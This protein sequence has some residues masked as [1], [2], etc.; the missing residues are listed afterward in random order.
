MKQALQIGSLFCLVIALT[1]LGFAMFFSKAGQREDELEKLR[2]NI[3]HRQQE[4]CSK[5]NVSPENIGTFLEVYVIAERRAVMFG[6]SVLE[7]QA[8]LNNTVRTTGCSG[9][10][11]CEV[12][13]IFCKSIFLA[14]YSSEFCDDLDKNFGLQLKKPD[15]T[16]KNLSEDLAAIFIKVQSLNQA[17]S[18]QLVNPIVGGIYAD[19]FLGMMA[20][21]PQAQ[22]DAIESGLNGGENII[23]GYVSANSNY[24]VIEDSE[25]HNLIDKRLNNR[26]WCILIAVAF[27][28]FS[29]VAFLFSKFLRS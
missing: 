7:L 9:K 14:V 17:Q 19:T 13:N 23:A 5:F 8:L 20:A 3:S 26:I 22:K 2:A 29:P 15:G 24:T 18:R 28:I 12:I 21:Y 11:A 6:S 16:R 25:L 1:F 10:T 27:A 4:F